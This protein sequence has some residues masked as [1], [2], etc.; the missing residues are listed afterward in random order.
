MLAI[1]VPEGIRTKD[2]IFTSTDTDALK[3]PLHWVNAKQG[4]ANLLDCNMMAK[5]T[6]HSIEHAKAYPPVMSP[7]VEEKHTQESRQM[8]WEDQDQEYHSL[9]VSSHVVVKQHGVP[10]ISHVF[11]GVSF[12]PS[13]LVEHGKSRSTTIS[14]LIICFRSHLAGPLATCHIN[15][16][17][18]A[19]LQGLHPLAVK[20]EVSTGRTLDFAEETFRD[21]QNGFRELGGL[22]GV[23]GV[24][25][26]PKFNDAVNVL[27]T[28]GDGPGQICFEIWADTAVLP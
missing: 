2:I 10:D 15:P 22:W 11:T 25:P 9:K 3:Y 21:F 26:S 17:I 7:Q 20:I 24:L 8:E 18:L 6:K 27:A 19:I 16:T 13:F 23:S 5:S 12:P 4:L 14:A 1:M 28:T